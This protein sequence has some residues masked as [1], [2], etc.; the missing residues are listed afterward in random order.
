[1]WWYVG[2]GRTYSMARPRQV[3][4][5][6]HYVLY[7]ASLAS[8]VMKPFTFSLKIVLSKLHYIA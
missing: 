8:C 2:W 7:V 4:R 3:Y 6:K 5:A 1:M